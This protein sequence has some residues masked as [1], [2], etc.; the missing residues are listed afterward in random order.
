MGESEL[1]ESVNDLIEGLA[2]ADIADRKSEG[3]SQGE[4]LKVSLARALVHRPPNLLLDEPTNGLDVASTRTMRRLIREWKAEG[5]CVIF[6]SHIMQEVSALC[7][8]LVIMND[9]RVV[10]K[11]T[12]EEVCLQ[13]GCAHLEGAFVR[14]SG[15]DGEH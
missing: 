6:S 7:D 9:G 12:P 14:L 1:E 13:A 5:R 3:F 10:A 4:R 8:T 2:M 11:G 15:I